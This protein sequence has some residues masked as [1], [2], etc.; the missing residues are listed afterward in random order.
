MRFVL[1]PLNYVIAAL[2]R[3]VLAVFARTGFYSLNIL[4]LDHKTTILQ[5]KSRVTQ[6]RILSEPQQLKEKLPSV[7]AVEGIT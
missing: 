2:G 6:S 3:M 7:N 1:S 4:N 5:K